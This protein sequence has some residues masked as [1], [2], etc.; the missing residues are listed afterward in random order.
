MSIIS[1]LLDVAVKPVAIRALLARE[2]LESGITYNPLSAKLRADPYA[3]Y[4][5][6]RRKDPVHRMRLQN[7]W[8]LTNFEDV[9]LV[10]RD[11]RRF[12]NA[13]R[14]FGYIPYISMLDLDPTEHTRIRGLAAKGFTPRSVAELEPRIQE[15]VDKLLDDLAGR[16]R[17]DL[18]RDF[19]FPLPVIVIAEMLGVPPEDREKF[20]G[21]SNVV[22]LT[23]DPLLNSEQIRQVRQAIEE[24]FDYFE[25]MAAARRQQ[26]RD[27]LIST[28]VAAEEDGEQLSRDDLLINLVLFLAAGNETTRNLI[29]NGTLALLR[30]PEQLQRLRDNPDLLDSAIDELLRYDSP[31]QLNGRI[32]REPLEIGGKKVEP[33]QRVLCLLGAANR[34]PAAFPNPDRLDVGRAPGNHLAFSRGIHYCLGAP[35]ARLE[36]RVAFAALLAR[37]PS[38][39][40]AAQPRYRNQITLRGLEELWVET[41]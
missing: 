3:T 5:K 34:D 27:D 13:G 1:T 10:L 21:W 8:V 17:F 33:G 9:D 19:A 36:G 31:V 12:G 7:A 25:G 14:D 4:E 35:L 29:G 11:H 2:W 20:N 41:G 15:T 37:Y 30:H 16:P 23:V 40:L 26:P 28:L 32:A 24:L 18:I 6:L 22:A 38:L 39:R